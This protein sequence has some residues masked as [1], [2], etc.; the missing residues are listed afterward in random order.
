[1]RFGPFV[2]DRQTGEL[3]K[4]SLRIRLSGQP[5]EV[6]LY[7]LERPGVLVTREELR[8]RLS[9]PGFIFPSRRHG[10]NGLAAKQAPDGNW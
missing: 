10:L 5:L 8:Q 6:L 1:V 4:H 3:R 9:W 2:L 7:L